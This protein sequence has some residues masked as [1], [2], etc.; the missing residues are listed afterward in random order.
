VRYSALLLASVLVAPHLTVYDLVILAPA[1]L[2]TADW[3]V[4]RTPDASKR[5]LGNLLYFVYLLPLAGPLAQWTHVQLSVIAMAA[6]LFMMARVGGSSGE[7][8][9][10]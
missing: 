4:E 5:R 10:S 7:I 1:L 9:T 2:L 6:A 3:L 8:S